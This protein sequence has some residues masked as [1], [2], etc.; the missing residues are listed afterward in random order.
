MLIFKP[1]QIAR[2]WMYRRWIIFTRNA[3]TETLTSTGMMVTIVRIESFAFGERE[4]QWRGKVKHR[5]SQPHFSTHKLYNI[6]LFYLSRNYSDIFSIFCYCLGCYVKLS[7]AST[8][9][10]VFEYYP[11]TEPPTTPGMILKFA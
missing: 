1:N 11:P 2:N 6:F 9:R 7:N 5:N 3:M 8:L 10:A 4:G